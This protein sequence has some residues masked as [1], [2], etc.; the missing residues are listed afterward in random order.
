MTLEPLL[1][2]SPVI[3]IHACAAIAA[4]ILGG[5]VLFRK[6]GDNPHKRLGRVWAALMV[7]VAISSFF[8]WQIRLFGLFSPIHILS[9]LTLLGLWH[10]IAAVR[11]GRIQ[12]HRRLMQRL[13]IGALVV[14][15]F[16]TFMPGRIMYRV[17]FGTDGAGIIEWAVFLIVF[18]AIIGGGV[19]LLRERL[20]WRLP[21]FGHA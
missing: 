2:A 1:S 21:R 16:F 14:A 15:G 20:G 10:A 12:V 4:F 6:K 3:Q 5:A 8:I 19:L 7:I 11:A 17:V 13:Y 9:V 18:A